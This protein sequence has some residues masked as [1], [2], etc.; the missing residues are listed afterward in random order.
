M[1]KLFSSRLKLNKNFLLL[2][3][4]PTLFFATSLAWSGWQATR[5]MDTFADA[6]IEPYLFEDF[7]VKDAGLPGS[8]TEVIKWPL[9]WIQG[10]LPYTYENY[11]LGQ[12]ALYALSMGLMLALFTV[13][14]GRKYYAALAIS[15]GLLLFNDTLAY[16]IVQAVSRNIEFPIG[17]AFA[18]SLKPIIYNGLRLSKPQL[19]FAIAMAL[20]FSLTVAGDSIVIFSFAAPLVVLPMLLWLFTGKINKGYL[21]V[22]LVTLATVAAGLALKK[23]IVSHLFHIYMPSNFETSLV[24]TNQLLPSLQ[25]AAAQYFELAGA[26]KAFGSEIRVSNAYHYLMVIL[27]IV[28][29]YGLVIY[30]KR[31]LGRPG[32]KFSPAQNYMPIFLL[33][34]FVFTFFSYALSQLVLTKAADGNFIDAGGIRYLELLPLIAACGI[35]IVITE[36]KIHHAYSRPA[37]VI[38]AIVCTIFSA[39]S[40]LEKYSNTVAESNYKKHIF[41]SAIEVAQKENITVIGTGYWTAIPLRFYSNNQIQAFPVVGCNI[42]L[43]AYNVR[44]SWHKVDNKTQKSALFVLRNVDFDWWWESCPDDKIRETYGSPEKIIPVQGDDNLQLWTYNY[45]V[46]S[47]VD[48]RDW[49]Q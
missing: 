37:F 21:Y 38:I 1:I 10:I 34:T 2:F 20:I 14:L 18:L 35:A 5:S 19:I 30:G 15:L 22:A 7:A 40:F 9:F 42:P 36:N 39:P 23:L 25:H 46:R 29:L 28:G 44:A 3:L 26:H 45:D 47:K 16:W 41:N 17:I 32:S 4:V 31:H 11:A 48:Q 12:L 13:I 33:L 49:I 43:P 8:H 6:L 27:S 24:S